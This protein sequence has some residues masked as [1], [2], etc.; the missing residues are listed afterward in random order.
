MKQVKVFMSCG[1]VGSCREDVLEF[2]DDA[3]D[4]QIA[5]GCEI[6][7][8]QHIDLGWEVSNE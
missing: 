8:W 5:E 3:T 7:A 2:E 4:E 1:V 6:W